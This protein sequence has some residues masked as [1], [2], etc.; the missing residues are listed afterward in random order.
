VVPVALVWGAAVFVLAR[1]GPAVWSP[2]LV[3]AVALLVRLPL[4][5]TPPLLSDDLYRYLWEGTVL[6]AGGDPFATAPTAWP[7][8]DDPL[9]A[10]VNHPDV[11]S[12]Y[13][14]LAL[15]WFRA[16]AVAGTPAAVQLATA[17]LDAVLAGVL[18]VAAGPVVAVLYA[19][20]PLPV[21]ES[22]C[23]GHLEVPAAFLAALGV[24]SSRRGRPTA[25]FA[26]ATAGALV[27]M[28]PLVVLPTLW[29]R[30]PRRR[31]VLAAGVA[32]V[33]SVALLAVQVRL[34][35]ATL[36]DG[37][38]TYALTW[39]FNG[40]A[41]PLIEPWLGTATRP[42]LVA[43]GLVATGVAV[44]RTRDPARVWSVAATSFVLLSPTVHPW[45][46][47]WA[48]VPDLLRGRI[49][50]AAASIPLLG[51]YA[52]LSTVDPATGGWTEQP[53]LWWVTWPPAIVLLVLFRQTSVRSD[54]SPIEP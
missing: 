15:W 3:V 48:L 16:L 53:W 41:W 45:Y 12:V 10:R 31:A 30:M 13:P 35:P 22:A 36:L 5:G 34:D 24:W 14:P 17:A 54:P 26:L 38:R 20:H 4:V 11:P 28:F 39:S 52:V 7:G 43:A 18:C 19:L 37:W 33:G 23:G 29:L 6:G 25:A 44:A 27:K 46:V 8:L 42:V 21:L 50:W 9:R 2:A 32:V 40:F 1:R 51:S 49:A 47:S